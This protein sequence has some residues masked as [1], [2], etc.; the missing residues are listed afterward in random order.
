MSS[1]LERFDSTEDT[2]EIT[3]TLSKARDSI[4]GSLDSFNEKQINYVHSLIIIV[5]ENQNYLLI[6][7]VLIEVN[8]ENQRQ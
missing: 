7:I 8:N 4:K 2:W 3:S 1:T 6:T 5:I